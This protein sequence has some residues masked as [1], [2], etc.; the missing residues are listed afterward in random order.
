MSSIQF[1]L[2]LR[3]IVHEQQPRHG[4][5]QASDVRLET[6]QVQLIIHERPDVFGEAIAGHEHELAG[7]LSGA[8]PAPLGGRIAQLVR[9]KCAAY[10]LSDLIS[11][12]DD[13]AQ[14]AILDAEYEEAHA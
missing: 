13:M 4:F 3:D 6:S 8:D 2:M 11:T 1:S 7:L 12:A 10:I 5:Q 14:E 9:E